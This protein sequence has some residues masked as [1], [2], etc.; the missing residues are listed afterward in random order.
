MVPLFFLLHYLAESWINTDSD[1]IANSWRFILN[2]YCV[3][4]FFI[5]NPVTNEGWGSLKT[6]E[7]FLKDFCFI[8]IAQQLANLTPHQVIQFGLTWIQ[9]NGLWME[10]KMNMV[11]EKK[12]DQ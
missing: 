5:Y 2:Y 8:L 1:S 3:L 10:I 11:D 6:K 4:Y 12:C 7:M 9:P